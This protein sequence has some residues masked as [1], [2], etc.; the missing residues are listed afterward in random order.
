MRQITRL[1]LMAAL[2][3]LPP[4]AT[5]DTLLLDSFAEA[6]P[7]IAHPSRGSRMEQVYEKF[8]PAQREVS[9]VGKPPITRW[10]YR[11]FTVYFERDRVIETVIH[12]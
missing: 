6:S 10:I 12:R 3:T 5:G 7:N 9:A 8:G 4:L 2:F 1:I 11:D